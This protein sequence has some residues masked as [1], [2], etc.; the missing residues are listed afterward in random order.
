MD[1]MKPIARTAAVALFIGAMMS[2]PALAQQEAFSALRGIDAQ[3]LSPQE[4]DAIAGKL[5]AYDIAAALTALAATLA[6]SP[7]LQAADEK[8]AAYFVTNAVAIN[9]AFL[10]YGI[11]TPCQSC[12]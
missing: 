2:T 9:A 11:L 10:R 1:V 6:G 7:T 12:K 8:L 3:A 4:M 5:N